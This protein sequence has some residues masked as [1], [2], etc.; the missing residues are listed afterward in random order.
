[1]L[2]RRGNRPPADAPRWQ[3]LPVPGLLAEGGGRRRRSCHLVALAGPDRILCPPQLCKLRCTQRRLSRG[4][5]LVELRR[6]DFGSAQ[7]RVRLTPMMNL[8]LK[9]VKQQPIDPLALN[10]VTAVYIND[11]IEIGRTQALDDGN[12]SPELNA[13]VKPSLPVKKSH[14]ALISATNNCGSA[15]TMTALVEIVSAPSSISPVAI[16]PTMMAG[17]I[18][19]A[20]LIAFR[21]PEY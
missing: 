14:D 17:P 13:T 19:W 10:A 15:P 8:M 21:S 16:L 18:T 4:E 20:A 9:Q 12:Q 7:H 1:V 3:R 11:A 2:V 5:E 6:P